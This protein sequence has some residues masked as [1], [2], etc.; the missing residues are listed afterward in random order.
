M[1]EHPVRWQWSEPKVQAV[2]MGVRALCLQTAAV[3]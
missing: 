3:R 2:L 1:M